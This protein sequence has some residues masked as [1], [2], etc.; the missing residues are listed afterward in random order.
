MLLEQ[1]L[2]LLAGVPKA[3]IAPASAALTGIQ[4]VAGRDF[5]ACVTARQFLLLKVPDVGG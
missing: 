3:D 4:S 2:E 5:D 1:P